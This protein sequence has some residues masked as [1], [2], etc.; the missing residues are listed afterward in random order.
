MSE[1]QFRPVSL[2]VL[3]A[4]AI[5]LCLPSVSCSPASPKLDEKPKEGVPEKVINAGDTRQIFAPKVDIL[6]VIA[7][8]SSMSSFQENLAKNASLFTAE[9]LKDKILDFHIGVVTAMANDQGR[10]PWG[11]RLAGTPSYVERS[12]PNVDRALISN[13]NVGSDAEDPVALFE[14][15]RGALLPPVSLNENKGFLR[16]DADLAVMFFSD[17]DPENE[18][19]VAE[20]FYNDLVAIKG[21]NAKKVFIYAADIPDQPDSSPQ[22]PNCS[23][24][25]SPVLLSKLLDLAHGRSFGFS[26]CSRDFGKQMAAVSRQITEGSRRM[27]LTRIP[28]VP[29]IEVKYGTQVIPHDAETGWVYDAHENSLIFGPKMVLSQQAPFTETSVTFTPADIQ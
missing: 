10:G 7:N 3:S 8:D 28:Y 4:L 12:T 2:I 24:E 6:L 25:S 27:L 9:I 29:S 19:E 13:M 26:L 16:P 20:N 18:G 5:C 22:I 21:G 11:G 15:V 23:A 1:L 14:V 17:T